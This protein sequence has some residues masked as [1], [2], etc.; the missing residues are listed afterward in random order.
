[1]KYLSNNIETLQEE[2]KERIKKFRSFI[3]IDEHSEI[4]MSELR[5]EIDDRKY[6]LK[7]L[8]IKKQLVQK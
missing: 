3:V 5:G 7:K 8:K 4:R 6:K 2:I 1:M